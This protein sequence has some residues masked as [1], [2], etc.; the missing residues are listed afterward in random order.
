M[1]VYGTVP[2]CN[3]DFPLELDMP[4]LWDEHIMIK[5]K[6]IEVL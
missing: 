4:F 5:L 1:K 2:K 6:G 3:I